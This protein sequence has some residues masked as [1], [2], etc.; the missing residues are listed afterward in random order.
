VISK[1]L[2]SNDATVRLVMAVACPVVLLIVAVVVI[3]LIMHRRHQKRMAELS[4]ANHLAYANDEEELI[5]LRA[6][7]AGDSTLREFHEMDSSVTSGSGSG[8]PFHQR[9]T[10]AREI[11]LKGCIGKGRYGEVIDPST[12]LPR[13]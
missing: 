3:L 4:R 5:G 1:V 9:R 10:I 8:M 12:A 6:R 7:P 11:K 13:S 2:S